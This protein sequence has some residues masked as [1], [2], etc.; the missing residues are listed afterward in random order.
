M[1]TYEVTLAAL[2]DPT[3]RAILELLRDGPRSVGEIAE[4]M[5][6]SRPAVSQH[7]GVLRQARL[8]TEERQGTRH[9][10]QADAAGLAALKRYLEDT[11]GEVL[12][13][14]HDAARAE[15]KDPAPRGR[16]R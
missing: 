1:T 11:W 4:A 5:P 2:A 16:R 3:R 10:Y 6:V 12:Q 14:F 8:V 7:L 15:L 13:S 9:L